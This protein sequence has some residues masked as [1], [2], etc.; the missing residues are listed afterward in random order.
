[1]RDAELKTTTVQAL[2]RMLMEL[3]ALLFRQVESRQVISGTAEGPCGSEES[4]FLTSTRARSGRRIGP[5]GSAAPQAN[6]TDR[7]KFPS[8]GV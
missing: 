4:Q 7:H 2:S 5:L 6:K 3:L 8:L 1:M